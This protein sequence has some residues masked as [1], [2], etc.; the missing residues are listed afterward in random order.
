MLVVVLVV[1]TQ[2]PIVA[3]TLLALV[4]LAAKGLL[5]RVSHHVT[6][7]AQPI[8]V[9]VSGS[10]RRESSLVENEDD[11]LKMLFLIVTYGEIERLPT[12]TTIT[13]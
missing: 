11:S 6:V 10:V 2:R 9:K 1:P 8:I 3:V 4:E 12:M 7:P 5:L 13:T